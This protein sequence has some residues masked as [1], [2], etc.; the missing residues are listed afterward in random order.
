VEVIFV[1]FA[2]NSESGKYFFKFDTDD[3]TDDVIDKVFGRPVPAP[4]LPDDDVSGVAVGGVPN[5]VL[6]GEEESG[7]MEIGEEDE[8]I[9]V[10]YCCTRRFLSSGFVPFNTRMRCRSD[11]DPVGIRVRYVS[12]IPSL[13]VR[14]SFSK[15]SALPISLL[16][17]RT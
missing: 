4:V 5:G 11:S 16:T 15:A 10:L 12:I 8:E 7:E 1:Y 3:V 17:I 14:I 2:Q 13:G 6:V 9:E